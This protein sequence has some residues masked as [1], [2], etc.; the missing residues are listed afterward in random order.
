MK[1]HRRHD[2]I[3]TA[4]ILTVTITLPTVGAAGT[5]GLHIGSGGF[6]VSV[7]FG[8]WGVYTS[9]WSDPYWSFSFDA[10]LAGY[11]EWTWVSG[12]GRVWRPWVATSWRPYTYG[13]WVFTSYG[14]TWV[15]YEPW[16][17]VP[18]HYGS[19]AYTVFGWVWVPGYSYSCANVVWVR[20]G[21]YVGWYARPPR[22]W[23]HAQHGFYHGYNHGYR[24]GYGSGYFDGYH[25]GWRDAR[26]ATYVDWRHFGSENVSRHSVTH[27]IA[28]GSRIEGLSG[29]PTRDEIQRRGGG[30]VA[31]TAVSRRTVKMNGREITVARPEGMAQSIERNASEA[32]GSALSRQAIERRQP[33]VAPRAASSAREEAASKPGLHARE[34]ATVAAQP[35]IRQ[36]SPQIQ[37]PSNPARS[38]SVRQPLPA[39]SAPRAAT[40][41]TSSSSNAE[42]RA[43]IAP[44]LS[45]RPSTD[46]G[47]AS[48]GT[49]RS[50]PSAVQ[51]RQPSS[52]DQSL[53]QSS[54]RRQ[55]ISQ[56]SSLQSRAPAPSRPQSSAAERPES[57][58]RS[59]SVPSQRSTSARGDE[60][61]SKQRTNE[62]S[63]KRRD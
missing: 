21:G 55:S 52:K 37:K 3:A 18:H 39:Q 33:L 7:G 26:Y 49:S 22:G 45:S 38:S 56:P 17:Y 16:G 30:A 58:S 32:V 25:D 44:Q 41:V 29:G 31:E 2:M 11:G 12:L 27:T 24:D 23:S 5:F 51:R 42:R 62:P 50:V 14:W 9:S 57:A 61:S 10:T 53:S 34:P 6:G 19:W 47:R 15:A 60:T 63:R 13:R 48:E 1:H 59:A 40:R 36:A 28:S 43:A 8:D 46:T 20:T 35:S 54:I 4:V